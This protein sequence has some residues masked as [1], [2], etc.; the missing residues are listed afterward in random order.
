MCINSKDIQRIVVFG[1]WQKTKNSFQ[2]KFQAKLA[3]IMITIW[4]LDVE[5]IIFRFDFQVGHDRA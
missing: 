5:S 4:A 1:T 3:D 2:R